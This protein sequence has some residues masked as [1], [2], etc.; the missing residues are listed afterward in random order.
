MESYQIYIKME[1]LFCFVN[2]IFFYFSVP[3]F[4]LSIKWL[5]GYCSFLLVLLKDKFY[6]CFHNSS[7]LV[8]V[9]RF[10]ISYFLAFPFFLRYI[11][12]LILNNISL[13]NKEEYFF[14]KSNRFSTQYGQSSRHD[15][16]PSLTFICLLKTLYFQF[17]SVFLSIHLPNYVLFS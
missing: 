16:S 17:F 4:G 11:F 2:V 3:I 12:V 5:S 1:S 13:R 10:C 8:K 15:W 14:L 9:F 7:K 6:S